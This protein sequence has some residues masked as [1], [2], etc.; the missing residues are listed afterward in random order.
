MNESNLHQYQ[1][2]AIEHIIDNPYSALFLEPGLGKTICTLTAITKIKPAKTLIIAPKR[3]AEDTWSTEAAKWDHLKHLT[4]SLV[5]G[6]AGKRKSALARKADIYVINRE[7]VPWL[8]G[9]LAGSWPFDMLAI[10]ELSSFKSPKAIRFKSLRMVRPKIKRVLGLT[11]TPAPNGLL[12]LWPQIY[13]LDMGERLGKTITGYRNMYFSPGL[14]KNHVVYKYNLEGQKDDG[15]LGAGIYEKEIYDKI[16]DICISMKAEDWLSLPERIN[17]VVDVRLQPATQD[18]YNEFE[19]K[20]VLAFAEQEVT[21]LNAA[22]LT[23][24]LLQ[25]SNGAVYDNDKSYHEVHADKIEA[26]G[27]II[28]AANG[29][30]VLVFYSYKSDVERIKQHLKAYKPYALDGPGDI[31]RWNDK[32]I[33]VLLAHPASAGHG[34]NMQAGGNIIVW[35][36]LPWSLELYQ[37]ANARLDRQGQTQSVIVHHLITK[38]TMDEDVYAALERKAGSQEALMQAVKA[39]IRKYVK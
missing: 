26:L 8:I 2:H 32:E 15:L 39:R 23:N 37:Q 21:A 3:V 18:K 33:P 7:N 14:Q 19:K 5:L 20:Q 28:E 35:F 17:R 9:Y 6:D 29:H 38:G 36:G 4:L 24:K 25:F 1:Q 30:P 22:A 27:E 11:G 34:L 12:D 31:K 16:S 13:L 10:D